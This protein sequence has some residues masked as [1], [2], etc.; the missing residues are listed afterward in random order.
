MKKSFSIRGLRTHATTIT[1]TNIVS[2]ISANLLIM[3]CIAWQVGWSWPMRGSRAC[4][5]LATFKV[6]V[7]QKSLAGAPDLYFLTLIILTNLPLK[8]VH[9][10]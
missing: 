2:N 5:L 3:L 10:Y 8:K 9:R 6:K 4:M 1:R 7:S